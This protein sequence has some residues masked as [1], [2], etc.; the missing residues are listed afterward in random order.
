M[1]FHLL[2]QKIYTFYVF[3]P[4]QKY[5]SVNLCLYAY[6]FRQHYQMGVIKMGFLNGIWNNPH[7]LK[8]AFSVCVN[9]FG[10]EKQI[11]NLIKPV[12]CFVD[13][14]K[15]LPFQIFQFTK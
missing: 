11:L 8:L 9:L 10:H 13:P 15:N 5:L 6:G 7:A 12:P 14:L 3:S 4:Y 1:I 2:I